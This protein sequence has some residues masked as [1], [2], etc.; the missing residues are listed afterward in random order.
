[1][2]SLR[3]RLFPHLGAALA[4]STLA[5]SVL[6]QSI[7][8]NPTPSRDPGEIHTASTEK[9]YYV[10]REDCLADDIFTFTVTIRSS[11][12]YN[13]EVWAAQSA[14]CA[15]Y[16]SRRPGTA[17][18]WRVFLADANDGTYDIEIRSR[19]I[20]TRNIGGQMEGKGTEADCSPGD[21]TSGGM[22]LKLYFLLVNGDQ[23][24][25]SAAVFDTGIDLVG[26]RAPEP[27]KTTAGEG[28]LIVE[29]ELTDA[30]DWQGYRLYCA[31]AD[32][33]GSTAGV[34][35]GGETTSPEPVAGAGG[36]AGQSTT[37]TSG[38]ANPELPSGTAGSPAA[39]C[40]SGALVP[41]ELPDK[42]Y[43]CGSGTGRISTKGT[44]TGLANGVEYAVG[45]AGIDL[46]GNPG[47][48]SDLACGTPQ[49][50]TTF[51]ES[52][53]EAGGTAGG[54]FCAFG[55]TPSPWSWAL[56]GATT[57]LGLRRR[58]RPRV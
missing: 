5:G 1:M 49:L 32:D 7:A 40:G 22:G 46:L 57:V 58:R 44:A 10:T 2:R 41:G 4:V 35:A 17:N 39:A 36:A 18:C 19:D 20:A 6:A 55:R 27:V 26:P 12:G 25:G 3:L 9:R 34:G 11:A 45:V 56:V 51:Y 13:L 38:A 48:L 50:V 29:W 21:L 43:L 42:A 30:E 47:P 33:I 54:G 28:K 52:Y 37:A 24:G 23:L 14:N 15:E 8:I 31:T 16:D 53:R